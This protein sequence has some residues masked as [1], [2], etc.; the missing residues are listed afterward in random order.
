MPEPLSPTIGFGMKVAVLPFWCATFL[1]T[2]FIVISS[3]AFLDQ[4]VEPRADFALAGR[5]HFVVMHFDVWPD[6]FQQ[7]C[8]SRAQVA[9]SESTGATG[10]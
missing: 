9:E 8:T 3:S 5:G 10:K 4:R 2:Y 7:S 6:R 1:I